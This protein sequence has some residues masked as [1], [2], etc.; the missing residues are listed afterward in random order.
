MGRKYYPYYPYSQPQLVPMK[1]KPEK[2]EKPDKP[3]KPEKPDTGIKPEIV[4]KEEI[5]CK[6]MDKDVEKVKSDV[7]YLT[8]LVLS[9]KAD[10]EAYSKEISTLKD[11]LAVATGENSQKLPS[12]NDNLPVEEGLKWNPHKL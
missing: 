1:A 9:L 6:G 3:V 4:C 11:K 8:S 2:P 12:E 5:V 7:Q 10:L